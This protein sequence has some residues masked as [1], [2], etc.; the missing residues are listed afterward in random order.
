M[1]GV[2]TVK[3]D[4]KDYTAVELELDNGIDGITVHDSELKN[5][6]LDLLRRRAGGR[7]RTG[8]KAPCSNSFDANVRLDV[9]DEEA[10]LP[11]LPPATSN[12]SAFQLAL[13][14]VPTDAGGIWNL[15]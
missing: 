14:T 5:A 7:R 6:T 4:G 11:A 2:D 3:V 8:V 13:E 10:G 9:G 12:P 15:G 1:T